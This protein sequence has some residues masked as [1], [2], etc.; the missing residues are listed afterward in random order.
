[1]HRSI[2]RK[3]VPGDETRSYACFDVYVGK[4]QCMNDRS[5]GV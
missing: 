1:M 4:K 2:V 5:E 3:L